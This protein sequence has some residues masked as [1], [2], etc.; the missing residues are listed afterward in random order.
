MRRGAGADVASAR[1][2]CVAF[3]ASSSRKKKSL[4]QGIPCFFENKSDSVWTSKGKNEELESLKALHRWMYASFDNEM[5]F[6]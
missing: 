2:E 5:S 6:H 1:T 3:A 4:F